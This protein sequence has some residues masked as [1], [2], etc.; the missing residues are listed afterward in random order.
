MS[1]FVT[2]TFRADLLARYPGLAKRPGYTRL[3]LHLLSG[4]F[5]DGDTGEVV[6]SAALLARFDGQEAQHRSR[7][8]RAESFLEDFR[9][10]VLPEFEWS[11]GW[12]YT[13][14][15]ARTA[16]VEG[17][18]PDVLKAFESMHL[19]IA[20]GARP[21][22]AVTGRK[23]TRQRAADE[24]K[25]RAAC[26]A[27]AGQ[28]VSFVSPSTQRVIDYQNRID[29]RAFSQVVNAN[30]AAAIE[31]AQAIPNAASRIQALANLASICVN[32]KPYIRPVENSPRAFSDRQS[33][34]T[35][36]SDIRRE[37]TK[38]WVDYDLR[39]AQLAIIAKEWD[40]PELKDALESSQ[41][42]WAV[43]G[44]R[45]GLAPAMKPALKRAVYSLVFGGS[46]REIGSA[47]EASTGIADIGSR[48]FADPLLRM[49][50]DAREEQVDRLLRAK[51]GVTALGKEVE[52]PY[53]GSREERASMAKSFLAQQAQSVEL[54]LLAPVYELAEGNYYFSVMLYQFD[55]FTVRYQDRRN[56]ALWHSRILAAVE[57]RAREL[58]VPTWLT[59]QPGEDFSWPLD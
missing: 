5:E 38:V 33:L 58:G 17:V 34:L 2:E 51:R 30:R 28:L 11:E 29:V 47:L 35:I 37:L 46:Q 3:L 15:K 27:R 43:L 57:S 39:A 31:M 50:Y 1:V 25:E 53:R 18:E 21:V 55:G 49:V 32:P 19:E 52:I 23:L 26:V 22:D 44:G 9:R 14:G 45:L 41:S 59:C 24:H 40:L 54:M 12:S 13:E 10:D 48:F 8:F 56:S 4:G 16:R 42:I 7:N 36:K 6:I 20:L